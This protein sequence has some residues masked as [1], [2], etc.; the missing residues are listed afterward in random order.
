MNEWAEE[1]IN[2][3]QAFC[4]DKKYYL[5]IFFARKSIATATIVP[6]SFVIILGCIIITRNHMKSDHNKTKSKLKNSKQ[7]KT[8]S[9]LNACSTP[10]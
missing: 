7:N 1:V 5:R 4:S 10:P 2:G 6:P 9:Q 8:Q 3:Q